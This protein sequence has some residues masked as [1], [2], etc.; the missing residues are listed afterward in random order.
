[1]FAHAQCRVAITILMPKTAIIVD[2]SVDFSGGVNSYVAPTIA[3]EQNPNGLKRNQLAWM[4]NATV[5]GGGITQRPGWKKLGVYPKGATG[6]YQ[7]KFLY[8]PDDGYP[9][10]I[11]VIGG[12]VWKIDPD[13]PQNGT[14]LSATFLTPGIPHYNVSGQVTLTLTN[15]NDPGFGTVA[16]YGS[17]PEIGK[18]APFAIPAIGN[19]VNVAVMT[20]YGGSLGVTTSIGGKNYTITAING[21]TILPSSSN[22]TCSIPATADRVYFC[23]AEQFLVIQAGDY[24]TL[25]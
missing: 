4:D 1:M 10:I 13:N 20:P 23:Q 8:E 15:V 9:Y 16:P 12:N 11:A 21:F 19:T 22:N 3:T 18:Y 2:G 17:T 7:G 6:K 14:N 25:S 24:S 5:R